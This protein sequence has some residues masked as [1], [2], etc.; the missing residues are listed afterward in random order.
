MMEPVLN[1]FRSQIERFQTVASDSLPPEI[2]LEVQNQL[3]LFTNQYNTLTRLETRYGE[4]LFQACQIEIDE[5]VEICSS[6]IALYGDL[7]STE[8]VNKL[9]ENSIRLNTLQQRIAGKVFKIK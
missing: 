7:N 3:S 9:R 8:Q 2:K 1:R 5:L 6:C 4:A